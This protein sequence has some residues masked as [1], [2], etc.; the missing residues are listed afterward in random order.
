MIRCT[1]PPPLPT[2]HHT[3]CCCGDWHTHPTTPAWQTVTMADLL[4]LAL[5]AGVAYFLAMSAAHFTSFKVPVLFIYYD[6]PFYEYQDKII[7]FCAFTYVGRC[8]CMHSPCT[9]TC[10]AA[11]V[12][13]RDVCARAVCVHVCEGWGKGGT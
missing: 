1:N 9:A 13:A 2:A 3:G 10:S 5:L 8:T 12:C 11:C 7:S 4:Q 6:T